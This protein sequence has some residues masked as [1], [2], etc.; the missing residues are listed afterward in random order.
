MTGRHDSND[1][2]PRSD[3]LIDDAL[4]HDRE[5]LRRG[6]P[7]GS[8]RTGAAAL[9][10]ATPAAGA[11]GMEGLTA[12]GSFAKSL[13]AKIAASIMAAGAGTAIVLTVLTSMQ[14]DGLRTVDRDAIAAPAP[15][16]VVPRP[17]SPQSETP[18]TSSGNARTNEA[19]DDARAIGPVAQPSRRVAPS[20]VS[21]QQPEVVSTEA[22][23][24]V[25]PSERTY[26]QN[27]EMELSVKINERKKK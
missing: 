14:D 3:R 11:G 4:G 12:K 19:D 10:A 26:R 25:T 22:E 20:I 2:S 24:V 18:T 23:K 5:A 1:G 9:L 16:L 15:E 7:N 17:L 13:G 21:P 6:R 27:N 8:T